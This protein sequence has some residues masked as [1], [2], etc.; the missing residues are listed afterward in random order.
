MEFDYE[1][2]TI[3]AFFIPR[4][5]V[6]PAAVPNPPPKPCV[7]YII[8]LIFLSITNWTWSFSA[9]PCPSISVTALESKDNAEK[10][11]WRLWHSFRVG[12]C[13]L[14]PHPSTYAPSPSECFV[15]FLCHL[16][17]LSPLSSASNKRRFLKIGKKS[18]FVKEI[19]KFTFLE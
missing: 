14:L 7:L 8:L 6:L 18:M 17:R 13:W 9:G 3:F 19:H 4:C 11:L 15:C 10:T 5:S 12:G 1:T 16:W 2:C